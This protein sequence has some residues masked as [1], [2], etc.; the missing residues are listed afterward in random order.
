VRLAKAQ[1]LRRKTA[2]FLTKFAQEISRF[3]P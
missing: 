2:D 1:Y 3:A